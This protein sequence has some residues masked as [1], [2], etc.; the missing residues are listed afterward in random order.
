[1]F[2][3]VKAPF[4]LHYHQTF[5]APREYT[6]VCSHRLLCGFRRD[7]AFLNSCGDLVAQCCCCG[8]MS[9]LRRTWEGS[10]VELNCLFPTGGTREREKAFFFR[11]IFQDVELFQVLEMFCWETRKGR[12]LK[13]WVHQRIF[14]PF[15]CG[16]TSGALCVQNQ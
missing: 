2:R 6:L 1:M 10:S 4:E 9:H 13:S 15:Y 14:L 5:L 7:G 8:N 12:W 3:P 11:H 16:K